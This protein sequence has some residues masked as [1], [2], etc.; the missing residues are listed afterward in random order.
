[1]RYHDA[2]SSPPITARDALDASLLVV[3][4]G[5]MGVYEAEAYPFLR[6]EIEVLKTRLPAEAPTLGVCLGAQLIAAATGARVFPGGRF[7]LGYE[8]IELTEAG[9]DSCLAALLDDPRVLHWHGDTYDLPAGATRLASSAAYREQAFSI[10][11]RILGVQFHPEVDAAMLDVWIREGGDELAR[12]GTDAH[13]LRTTCDEIV[14]A[15]AARARALLH[16]WLR[17]AGIA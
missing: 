8:P 7:E 17:H 9:C 15:L 5:P 6:D 1:V 11:P 2:W 13:T 3:L 10:G 4:G 16:S 12:A 14:P